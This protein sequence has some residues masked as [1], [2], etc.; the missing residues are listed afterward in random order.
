MFHA[1]VGGKDYQSDSGPCRNTIINGE[2]DVCQVTKFG[3]AFL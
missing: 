3:L 1:V 2:W